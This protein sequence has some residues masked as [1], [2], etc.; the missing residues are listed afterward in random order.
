MASSQFKGTVKAPSAAGPINFNID[1]RGRIT[2]NVRVGQRP[3]YAL[4]GFA[5]MRTGN[6]I[7]A[8][9]RNTHNS[10]TGN[11]FD[12]EVLVDGDIAADGKTISGVVSAWLNVPELLRSEA[13]PQAWTF[14][15]QLSAGVPL[16]V[17]AAAEPGAAEA[18]LLEEAPTIPVAEASYWD[19]LPSWSK[20]AGAGLL[21]VGG[22]TLIYRKYK[23]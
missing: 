1:H 11:V 5:G 17:S 12:L 8:Q 20:T 18:A 15:A 3:D 22:L 10:G 16:N 23:R 6:Q 21:A 4:T 13:E 2:G 7:R 14:D 19:R 9:G